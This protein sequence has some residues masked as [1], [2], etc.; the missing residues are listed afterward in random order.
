[1]SRYGAPG[2]IDD[3]AHG[4]DPAALADGWHK[5]VSGW[6]GARAADSAAFF[7]ALDSAGDV[8]PI[9]WD[10]F[11]LALRS[12]F[13]TAPDP[14]LARQRSAETLAEWRPGGRAP[15]AVRGGMLGEPLTLFR[16]QQDEYCE[17][18]THRDDAGR[19]TRVDFSCEGPEYWTHIATD[20]EL[21]LRLYREHV[22][23]NVELSELFWDHD[24][25]I[26]IDGRWRIWARAGDYNVL[27]RWTTTDGIMHLTHSANTLE[28]EINL[29]A[30]ATV[31]RAVDGVIVDDPGTLICCSGFGGASRSSDPLIGFAV[32]RAV[33]AG[34]RVGL[35]DPVGLYISALNTGAF[36][37]GD[38]DPVDA[39][40][41]VRGDASEQRILRATFTPPPGSEVLVGGVPLEFGG[42]ITD[43]IQMALYGVVETNPA[44]VPE[45]A[46]CVAACCADPDRPAFRIVVGPKDSCSAIDWEL[47][48]PVSPS[49]ARG[50]GL[51]AAEIDIVDTTPVT[52]SAI[53]S[54]HR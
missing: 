37:D 52:E 3:F 43:H 1:M 17:W 5:T 35:A 16:R 47:L 9:A 18:F 54:R 38:G 29:A 48:G 31:L 44:G 41:V 12:W 46:G 6:V 40:R 4:A 39:W 28:A 14:E 50:P 32:N 2:N 49:D 51:A 45:A 22:D 27:N 15:R 7:D 23:A 13:A 26:S 10:G 53:I 42:H 34:K 33:S 30:D 24:V 11:P 8:V 20:P 36:T 21:C 25:A 19:I